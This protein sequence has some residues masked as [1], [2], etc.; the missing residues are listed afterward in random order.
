MYRDLLILWAILGALAGGQPQELRSAK[1]K[2]DRIESNYFKGCKFCE[3]EADKSKIKNKKLRERF[4]H[5]KLHFKN[6]YRN[7]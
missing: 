2:L 3:T 1:M 6:N 4:A 7:T 5:S